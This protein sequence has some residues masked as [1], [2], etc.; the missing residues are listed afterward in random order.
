MK[1][2]WNNRM[3]IMAKKSNSTYTARPVDAMGNADYTAEE[4]K[5]WNE[6]IIRQIPVVKGRACDE[7]I[8]GI[9]LLNMPLDRIPQCGE[10]SSVLRGITGWQ[11]E[12]V[13][14]LI[15][16]ERFF[17]LL[18]N[19]KF[20]AATFIRRRE[21]LDYLQEPDIFH[22]V[23]G[24]CPLLTNQ[25]YADFTQTYGRLG[26]QASKEDRAMLAK[27]YWFTIEFGLIKTSAGLRVYGGGVLSSKEETIYALESDVPQRKTFD[28]ID[29]L[30]TPYRIDIVQPVYFVIDSFDVLFQ[31]AEMDL[32]GLIHDARKLGM[33]PPLYSENKN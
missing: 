14:A 8:N 24:H 12:P 18:A 6:L 32:I 27:L 16:F 33:Y 31:L 22:E 1:K 2:Y 10:I 7:Y 5:L 23:F 17:H 30:R 20:P 9:Q 29:V 26:L 11:L 3:D 25:A 19:C 28:V 15:P 4:N 21:E 13:P